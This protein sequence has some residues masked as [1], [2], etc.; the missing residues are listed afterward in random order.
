MPAPVGARYFGRGS[1]NALLTALAP[2]PL[3]FLERQPTFGS[4]IQLAPPLPG[5]ELRRSRRRGGFRFAPEEG[6][7]V[8]PCSCFGIEHHLASAC[9]PHPGCCRAGKPFFPALLLP[10]LDGSR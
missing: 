1:P 8:P 3:E 7:R 4:H 5:L 9:T 10:R 6:R 2:A